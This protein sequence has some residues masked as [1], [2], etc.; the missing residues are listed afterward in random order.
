[1][2]GVDF[3]KTPDYHDYVATD[4]AARELALEMIRKLVKA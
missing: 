4:I 2:N 3:I 1:M